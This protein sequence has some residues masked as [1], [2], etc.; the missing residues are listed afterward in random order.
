MSV[1]ELSWNRLTVTTIGG[2]RGLLLPDFLA[3]IG[4][5]FAP[6]LGV[7]KNFAFCGPNFLMIFWGKNYILMPKISDDLFLAIDRTRIFFL[8]SLSLL[9]NC[10]ES[11]II[12]TYM[13]PFLKR[14][15]SVS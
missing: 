12:I 10:L 13:A 11:D 4:G 7:R 8:F 2:W 6:S 14:K 15:T 3:S 9:F 5:D 1:D